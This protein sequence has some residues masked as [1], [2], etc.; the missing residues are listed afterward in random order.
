MITIKENLQFDVGN[1]KVKIRL[2][3][4]GEWSF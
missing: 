4:K 3:K 1:L 2:T